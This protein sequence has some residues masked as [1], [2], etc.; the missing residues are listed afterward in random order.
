MTSEKLARSRLR[1][2]TIGLRNGPTACRMP[3]EMNV[4]TQKAATTHQP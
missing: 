4:V 3:V 1:S 2:A